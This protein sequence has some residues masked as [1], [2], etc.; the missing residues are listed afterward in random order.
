MTESVPAGLAEARLQWKECLHEGATDFQFIEEALRRCL[1]AACELICLRTRRDLDCRLNGEHIRK[2][3]LARLIDE[4]EL[5]IG[6]TGLASAL[7]VLVSD[8]NHCARQAYLQV[9]LEDTEDDIDK[10]RAETRR[11]AEIRVRASA[12][13]DALVQEIRRLD[14]LV[15]AEQFL[16][17]T[18]A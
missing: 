11:L 18:S 17:Q 3:G 1:C 6:R 8:R 10:L 13:R 5:Y 4:F 14:A 2:Y 16:L 9:L 7:R 12:T 15:C